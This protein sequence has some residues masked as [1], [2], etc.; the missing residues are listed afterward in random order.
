M[1]K[2]KARQMGLGAVHTVGLSDARD[3]ASE[4]RRQLREGVDPI[5]ARKR[6]RATR[7][8]QATTTMTFK[9]CAEAYIKS[10]SAGWRNAK[11]TTQWAN[12]LETY[13]YP[14]FGALPVQ[15]IDTRLV[16]KALDPIWRTKTEMA[17]RVRGRIEAVL[18]WATVRKYREGENPARWKGH[19]DKLLPAKSKIAVVKHHAALPY[20]DIGTFMEQLAER[21][22]ITAKGLAFQILTACRSGEVM[23]ATWSEI[24]MA[25]AVWTIPAERM[26]NGKEHRIPLSSGALD[27]LKGLRDVA[28]SDFVFPGSKPNSA[29]SNMAF[30]QLLK[31]M[32][33][34]D[35]TAHG[36]RSTFRDWAAEQTAFSREVAEMALAHSIGDKVEAAY[37][38]GDLF[39]KRRK[40]MEAWSM[41][42]ARNDEDGDNVIAAWGRS[43]HPFNA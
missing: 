37:R 16:M 30:L 31:R 15:L 5:E 13:S 26:K 17:S 25:G 3:A 19:L 7:D 36:F 21:E 43:P 35:L 24:D 38:R 14:I 28:V 34:N 2:S 9:D 10:H 33:R 41:I 32:G 23:A 11:H 20:E 22:S 27:I 40:L 42:C 18:D 4:C 8:L 39:E 12:T 29:L 6:E 1:L